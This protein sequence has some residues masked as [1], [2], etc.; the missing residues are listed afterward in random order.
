MVKWTKKCY[1]GILKSQSIFYNDLY[2][3]AKYSNV[4]YQGEDK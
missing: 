2:C 1:H 4:E 3:C